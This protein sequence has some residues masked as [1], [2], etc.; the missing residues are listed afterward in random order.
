MRT[1]DSLSKG[2]STEVRH[3]GLFSKCKWLCIARARWGQGESR[4]AAKPRG[5]RPHRILFLRA[6]DEG[7]RMMLSRG[8]GGQKLEKSNPCVEAGLPCR[9]GGGGGA[10]RS[11]HREAS[12]GTFYSL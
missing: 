1:G 6:G 8:R 12:L 7:R 9:A 5:S 4:V 2:N 10:R 3:Q 11:L